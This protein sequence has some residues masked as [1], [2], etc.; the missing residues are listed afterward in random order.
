MSSALGDPFTERVSAIVMDVLGNPGLLPRAL[1][2]WMTR[3]I[4]QEASFPRSSV[5]GLYATATSTSEFGERVHGRPVVL[6]VGSSPYDFLQ[7]QYDSTYERWVSSQV[8]FSP[9]TGGTAKTLTTSWS[10][11]ASALLGQIWVPW[12][13]D[14]FDAGVR[15]QICI[16]A[17]QAAFFSSGSGTVTVQLRGVVY[18]YND[19]DTALS[20]SIATSTVSDMAVTSSPGTVTTYD[21]SGWLDFTFSPNPSE[22]RGVFN[23]QGQVTT[24]GS[25][26]GSSGTLHEP[27]I[28]LR[29]VSSS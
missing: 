2:A 11:T 19:A 7:M 4:E 3:Y 13:K 24:T 12:L 21:A 8:V 20:A 17:K 16:A 22:S 5:S 28:Y 26:V 14:F 25:P 10:D 18:E 15:P 23:I 29:W 1:P 27:Y 9:Y 6:R